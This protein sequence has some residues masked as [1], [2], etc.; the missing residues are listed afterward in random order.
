MAVSTSFSF[1]T[2]IYTI[3]QKS[4]FV[5]IMMDTKLPHF[6]EPNRW[7]KLHKTTASAGAAPVKGAL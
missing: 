1:V 4:A 7:L 2:Y 6:A 5:K 3:P